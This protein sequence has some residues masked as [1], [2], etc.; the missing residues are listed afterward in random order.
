MHTLTQLLKG[1]LIIIVTANLII[2]PDKQLILP[3]YLQTLMNVN[4][5]YTF[6][7]LRPYVST[8]SAALYVYVYLVS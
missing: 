7:T 5:V 6:V 1:L 8:Q 3:H 4:W 2:M